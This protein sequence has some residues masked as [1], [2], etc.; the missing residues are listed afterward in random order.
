[1]FFRDLLADAI[2]KIDRGKALSFSGDGGGAV[3]GR[4]RD[5]AK[6]EEGQGWGVSVPGSA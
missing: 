2:E 6:E 5:R 4:K 3:S 1:M